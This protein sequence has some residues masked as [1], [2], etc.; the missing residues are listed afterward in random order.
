MSVDSCS[1]RFYP[2]NRKVR[3]RTGTTVWDAAAKADIFL[4]APCGG[5]GHCGKCRVRFS[6]DAPAPAD[7]EKELISSADLDGG[8]RLA[9]TARVVKD[10]LV[11]IL[12]ESEGVFPQMLAFEDEGVRVAAVLSDPPVRKVAL[13]DA[14]RTVRESK[15]SD[16]EALR[17]IAD[18]DESDEEPTLDFLKSLPGVLRV[19][20]ASRAAAV[21][22]GGR[23]LGLSDV[24]RGLYGIA[25]DVG[26]TTVAGAL[27]DLG[28]GEQLAVASRLNAQSARGADIMSRINFCASTTEGLQELNHLVMGTV[29]GIVEELCAESGVS[30][31][32]I[33]EAVV[34]GNTTMAHLF[35]GVSPQHLGHMPYTPVFRQPPRV[36]AGQLGLKINRHADVH[37]L[38]CIGGFV[39]AD[40]VGVILSRDMQRSDRIRMAVDI[41]TNGEIL[42]GSSERLLASSTA[43][44]P[45]LE[46]AEVSCGIRAVAGAIE[47][48]EVENGEL[49]F[50]VI[51]NKEPVGVCGS[52]LVD[53]V[54]ALVR[55]GVIDCGGRL[56][57]PED[58]SGQ[59]RD[60][61]GKRIVC[62]PEGNEFIIYG[63]SGRELRLTQ[64]DVRK[65][66]LAKG[67]IRAGIEM[68]KD[69]L[70]VANEDIE[71]VFIAGAFGN[72]ISKRSA[73][74]IG[75]L[76]PFPLERIKPVGNAAGAGAKLALLSRRERREA[77]EIAKKTAHVELGGRSA[78]QDAFAEA[79][80]FPG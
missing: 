58:M 25:L 3:V 57:A 36:D 77:A 70:G 80:G 46:G 20:D 41:G 29:N 34:V 7:R 8:V 48:V 47:R 40:S 39:G 14:A 32:D 38:P 62:K 67:A 55:N 50:K 15:T 56:L 78:F 30:P 71:V 68:L 43:A 54:A 65:I 63:D 59:V 45:A 16:I 37:L 35:L 28:S 19:A 9:C 49:A 1:I 42:L 6:E 17:A 64:G 31:N 10:S 11:E 18:T 4:D 27:M 66:Q 13:A 21:I 76:P 44:G 12:P 23:F 69:E 24:S 52:G 53:L 26:T 2:V 79:I 5:R 22:C 75:L 51:G 73:V 61:F 72:Y 60:R 33:W 74:A